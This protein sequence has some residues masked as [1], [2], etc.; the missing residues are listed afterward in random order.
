MQPLHHPSVETMTVEGVLYALSDP[1]RA[2]ILADIANAECP[3]TCSVFLQMQ[4]IKLPKSTLSKHFKILREAGLIRS[5]RKGVELQNTS[6]CAEINDRF[7]PMVQEILKAYALT[8][9]KNT[10]SSN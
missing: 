4:N 6:R 10:R 3:Q 9:G 5:V 2:Q 7:G 1:I 8:Y